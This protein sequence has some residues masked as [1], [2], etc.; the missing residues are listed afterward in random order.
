MAASDHV[1][2]DQFGS[3]HEVAAAGYNTDEWSTWQQGKC[4]TYACGLQ[5]LNSGLRFGTVEGGNHFF[6][7]DDTHAYDSAGRHPLPYSGIEG[8]GRSSLDEEPEWYGVPHDEAGPEGS[9]VHVQAAMEH[10]Q[11][12]GVLEGR[13]GRK[14]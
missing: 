11:R 8:G 4:G 12:H 5:R 2:H 7:H 6:A 9:E 14:K 10:A 3:L 13:Y 1:H